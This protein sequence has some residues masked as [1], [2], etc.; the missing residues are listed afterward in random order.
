V[1]LFSRSVLTFVAAALVAAC[2]VS[3]RDGFGEKPGV[4][5]P[6][7][8][9]D[10]SPDAGGGIDAG[11]AGTGPTNQGNS[12]NPNPN[13]PVNP[14]TPDAGGDADSGGPWLEAAHPAPPQIQDNPGQPGSGPVLAAPV[15]TAISFP[16]YDLTSDAERFVS[17]V[18]TIPYWTAA[19]GSYGVGTPVVNAPV[20]ISQSPPAT[21]SDDDIRTWLTNE[22]TQ[23]SDLPPA[24]ENSLY[25][26]FF[27]SSVT[28]TAFG[29]TSCSRGGFYGYHYSTKVSGVDVAFVVLP[30]CGSDA[31]ARLTSTTLAASHEIAE[32]VT[33][34]HPESL[35]TTWQGIDQDHIVWEL[36]R[37]GNGEVGDMCAGAPGAAF[38]PP[39]FGYT[40]QRI[41]SNASA[42]AGHD[43]CQPMRP[44]E[45]VYFNAAPVLPDHVSIGSGPAKELTNG[46]QIAPGAT[47][48]VEV[49]L[50]SD[51][52]SAPWTVTADD[53]SPGGDRLS[54]TWVE[55][56]G[57]SAT[58]Q[59]GDKLHLA[60]HFA[61]SDAAC[62]GAVF[63]ITS[64]L[65]SS[66]NQWFGYVAPE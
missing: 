58:G 30:E 52:P 63:R 56:N 7:G 17:T 10:V 8:G 1:N 55:G 50:F 62:G 35:P 3:E 38:I 54:F 22:L 44:D 46:V 49:D 65:G 20:H 14:G 16:G 42:A 23:T 51:G 12:N 15:F 39:G 32:A 4:P 25:I 5:P 21:V 61:E 40:V 48:I 43:P 24:T 45:A 33:D 59:N 36:A 47:A 53:L 57:T 66:T 18:G 28:L 9:S 37:G 34:P 27:P 6:S 60:I 2:S 13:K 11:D 26:L 19:V 31:E 29:Q 41:W 64:Q